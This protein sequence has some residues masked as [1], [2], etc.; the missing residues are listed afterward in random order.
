MEVTRVPP[1]K[2]LRTTSSTRSSG[3]E[4]LADM[5]DYN[6]DWIVGDQCN[7]WSTVGNFN[8]YAYFPLGLSSLP[9]VVAMPDKN[10]KTCNHNPKMVLWI[11][12]VRRANRRTVPDS[13]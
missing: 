13:C 12:V 1:K 7:D 2:P 10:F 9:V 3:W 11:G 4:P 8:Y 5:I 6:Y